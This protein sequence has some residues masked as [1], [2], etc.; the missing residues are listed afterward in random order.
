MER[1][2]SGCGIVGG[3]ELDG[4]TSYGGSSAP[5]MRNFAPHC[6][7]VVRLPACCSAAEYDVLQLGQAKRIIGAQAPG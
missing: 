4:S 1:T 3:A 5:G 7:Q 6:L 2:G